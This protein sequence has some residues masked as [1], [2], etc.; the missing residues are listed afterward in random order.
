M[1]ACERCEFVPLVVEKW[2]TPS[3]YLSLFLL[4]KQ[5]HLVE[6]GW[7]FF[8]LCKSQCS[9]LIT[10]LSPILKTAL[11]NHSL[12][13]VAVFIHVRVSFMADKMLC[14][15]TTDVRIIFNQFYYFISKFDWNCISLHFC[16][17]FCNL[18]IQWEMHEIYFIWICAYTAHIVEQWRNFIT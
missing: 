7:I 9:F 8:I 17:M 1:H 12:V 2:I 15:V 16:E 13:S 14:N 10:L 18:S 4:L 11:T 5:C 3:S 6:T